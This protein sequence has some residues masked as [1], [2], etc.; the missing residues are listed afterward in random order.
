MGFTG[1]HDPEIHP[2]GMV[3][4]EEELSTLEQHLLCCTPCVERALAEAELCGR[5]AGGH[6]GPNGS[7]GLERHSTALPTTRESQPHLG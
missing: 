2:A 3:I 7:H 6:A 5:D 4:D 1:H